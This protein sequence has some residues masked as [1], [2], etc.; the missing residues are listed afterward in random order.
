M[1]ESVISFFVNRLGDL[2][3]Q[4]TIL[5]HEVHEQLEQLQ[6]DMR[7]MQSFLKAADASAYQ[8]DE[9]V[10][11]LVNEIKGIAYDSED[12]VDTFILQVASR[13]RYGVLK[14]YA[15]IFNE[16]ID[17]YKTGRKIQAIQKRIHGITNRWKTFNI[18][19]IDEG[20]GTSS[21]NQKQQQLRR[22]YPH[23]EEEDAISLEKD[24]EALV[25]QLI[26][27][28]ERRGVISIVG[29]GGL[30]KT[31]L[32]TKL[33][34]HNLVKRH[35]DCSAWVFI[36]Q[37][38]QKKDVLQAILKRVSAPTKEEMERMNEDDLVEKLYHVLQEKRYLV[39]LDDIWSMDTWDLLKLAFPNGKV[40][41]KI[42]ITTR[43]KEVAMHA[44]PFS[45]PHE[46]RCLTDEESW[47]LLCKK[48][49]PRD[50]VARGD[51]LD[52]DMERLGR[53]MVKK[54]GGLPL[55]VVVLGGLLATKKSLYEWEKVSKNFHIHLSEG[56]L[57]QRVMGILALSY[58]DLPY[59]LKPC[60]LYLGLFPEDFEIS[61]SQLIRQWVAE[62]F[63]A[64][65]DEGEGEGTME[66]LAEKCLEELIFRCMVQVGR[67]DSNERVKTF[68]IHDLMRD[69]CIKE[70]KVDSFLEI[71]HNGGHMEVADSFSVSVAK[72]RRCAIHFEDDMNLPCEQRKRK[73]VERVLESLILGLKSL[74]LNFSSERSNV[75]TFPD[76]KPICRCNLLS[77][78]R[79]D[80]RIVNLVPE[81]NPFPQNLTKLRLNNSQLKQ[82]P[83][84][85]LENL[86]RLKILHLHYYSF[87]GKEM[88]CSNR[89]FPQ[90]ELLM[91][92]YL[93]EL[94]EWRVE[95]GAMPSLRHL[96]IDCC[97]KLR[98]VPE[99]LRFVTTLR[100]LE[101][102]GMPQNF[103]QR[104]QVL[105]G[106]GGQDLYKVQHIPSITFP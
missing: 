58:H 60:F 31:T 89:G 85:I 49:F 69:L 53:K 41:S 33:Y 101:I 24:M 99:G 81:N 5:L 76:L 66:D 6:T 83:M 106:R 12:V 71:V 61:T 37:Q 105:D 87:K 13:G 91:L 67:Q 28:E 34:N 3:K 72:A 1:A 10:R 64:L 9:Q 30:G 29:M 44:D 32:A 48:A 74:S 23:A 55:A 82:D 40:G 22:T 80:G 36:S 38:C 46:P 18:K 8:G 97:R 93:G 68:R 90:L 7:G 51:F 95:E 42:M 104:L 63:V 21:A 17:L 96:E 27:A 16:W 65:Q 86:P 75:K 43:N 57:Q 94:E 88:V 26:T 47:V 15:S 102:T 92:S 19:N 103:K 70:A 25:A 59:Y 77:K 11:N 52:A 4:E 84:A 100:E 2:L 73:Q 79:L 98:M 14:R 20:E 62:G 50:V 54:C 78:L 56:Q 45:L 39:V 35:F